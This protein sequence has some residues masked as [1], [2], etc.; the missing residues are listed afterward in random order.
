MKLFT[1]IFCRRRGGEAQTSLGG[2]AGCAS[3]VKTNRTATALSPSP[4]PNGERAGVRGFNFSKHWPPLPN[5][6]L[7]WGRRGSQA[8]RSQVFSSSLVLLFTLVCA[9]NILAADVA[10]DFASA[11]KLYAKGDFADAAMIYENLAQNGGGSA[12]VLFN[13]GNAEF[14]AGHLGK[15]I[16]AYRRAELLAPRDA[17]LRANLAFVRNQVQGATTRDG[18]WQNWLGSLTLNEGA[19]LTAIFFW[20]LFAL[21]AAGQLRPALTPKM[22]SVTRFAIVLTIFS[23]AVLAL[24]AANYFSSSVAVVTS[25]EAI[26]RSGPFDDAQSVFTAR[27]GAELSVIDRHDDWVQVANAAGKTGWLSTKQTAVLPGA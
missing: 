10:A 19:L 6:L 8:V 27:D 11:N 1:P 17:E 23:S 3:A 21:L 5:P 25:A 9:G 12:A 4:R 22:R 16:A 24:Q 20:L 14:K 15:A 7:L 26:A 18:R 2:N 13:A